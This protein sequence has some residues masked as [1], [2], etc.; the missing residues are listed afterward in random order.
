MSYRPEG[1]ENPFVEHQHGS[2]GCR[3]PEM[4][5]GCDYDFYEAVLD[6]LVAALRER[7]IHVNNEGWIEKRMYE[8]G[9]WVF[10]PD[11]ED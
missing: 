7:G 11:E 10:I 1:F 4:C 8:A 6:T 2:T 9:T 3:A 5:G